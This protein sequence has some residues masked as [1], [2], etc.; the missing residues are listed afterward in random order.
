VLS[1]LVLEHR[2]TARDP[3]AATAGAFEA[4][5]AELLLDDRPVPLAEA[6]ALATAESA[7]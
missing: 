7:A 4:R 3:L 2:L 1:R 6:V 5:A